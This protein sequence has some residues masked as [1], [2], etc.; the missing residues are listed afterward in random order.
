MFNR[1]TMSVV[2]TIFVMHLSFVQA[3]AE[4]RVVAE[5]VFGFAESLYEEG[6]YFRAIGEY[7]R[8]IY[9][10]PTD[11]QA[12]KATFRIAEGY[13][14]AKRW[15]DAIVACN[16][17]LSKYPASPRYF[18]MLYLKG[19]VEKLSGRYDEALRTFELIF[20]ANAPNYK[21]KAL[22]QK[23]LVMLER[24]DWRGAQDT[25]RQVPQGSPLF[26][27]ASVFAAEIER[28]DLPYKSP[29]TAGLLAAV[30]PGAG[31]L[32][33]ERPRD[34]LVAFLLNGAFI[35]GALEFF[36]H[37][38]YVAGGI[39]AFF[40]LGWYTGNIYSAVSSVHK[41][42]RNKENDLIQKL[43]DNF[44]LAL[45]RDGDVQSFVISHRF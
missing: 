3:R 16:Q 24:T 29:A 31:H 7:K 34:A 14:Q 18:E 45:Y 5:P 35:W 8:Y 26:P 20:I 33:A 23:A 21:D 15:P 40:E 27:A 6:D 38:N 12:E 22:Y 30:L 32:Y 41:Y 2:I 1:I 37:D 19:R 10:A 36:Q 17:F 44:S 13:F 28:K 11:N 9:L 42:N 39:F 43:K 25:L 4:D